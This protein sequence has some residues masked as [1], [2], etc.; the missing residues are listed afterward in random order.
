MLMWACSMIGELPSL[1]EMVTL[2]RCLFRTRCLL[3]R[4]V[5][6]SNFCL[7]LLSSCD[8]SRGSFLDWL[9]P[10][11]T[12]VRNMM[13]VRTDC[14]FISILHLFVKYHKCLSSD[15]LKVLRSELSGLLLWTTKVGAKEWGDRC[16]CPFVCLFPDHSL[17]AMGRQMWWLRN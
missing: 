11:M 13:C 7:E 3:V 14:L 15:W 4:V 10:N 6:V 1:G 12:C 16:R 17:F 9:N 5:F 8:Y 2:C